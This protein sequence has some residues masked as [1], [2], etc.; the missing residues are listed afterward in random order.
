MALAWEKCASPCL[1]D[2]A[3]TISPEV[4]LHERTL[5]TTVLNVTETFPGMAHLEKYAHQD[6]KVGGL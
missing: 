6:V 1:P 5:S 4:C 2:N 3:P